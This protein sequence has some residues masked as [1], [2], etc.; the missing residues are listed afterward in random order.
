MISVNIELKEDGEENTETFETSFSIALVRWFNTL[1]CLQV[2]SGRWDK[3]SAMGSRHWVWRLW[4][5]EVKAAKRKRQAARGLSLSRTYKQSLIAI[6]SSYC[7]WNRDLDWSRL[8]STLSSFSLP[9]LLYLVIRNLWHQGK[10][11]QRLWKLSFQQEKITSV[12]RKMNVLTVRK[13]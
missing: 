5:R 6:L 7:P 8:A 4:K 3:H 13:Y 11:N 12:L 2:Y 9:E 1:Y 10:L